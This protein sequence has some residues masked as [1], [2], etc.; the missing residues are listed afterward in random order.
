MTITRLNVNDFR[1]SKG[2]RRAS[3]PEASR[4]NIPPQGWQPFLPRLPRD[5]RL[6]YWVKVITSEGRVRGGRV[7][8]VGPLGGTQ[9][10]HFVGVQLSTPDGISDG[11]F[12]SRRYF[13]W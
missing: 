3:A 8:Y 2:A 12:S 11:T 10:E 6:D 5:L 4:D 1:E 9:K 13:Q 7:R